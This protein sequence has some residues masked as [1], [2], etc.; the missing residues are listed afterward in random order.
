[1]RDYVQCNVIF[2]METADELNMAISNFSYKIKDDLL[3]GLRLDLMDLM[4]LMG[5]AICYV[6][7]HRP[8]LCILLFFMKFCEEYT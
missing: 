7:Q 6:T 3:M 1:M 5:Q 8:K 2:W 4:E